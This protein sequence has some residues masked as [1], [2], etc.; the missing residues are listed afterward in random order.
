[1]TN[2][3]VTGVRS[4]ELGVTDLDRSA[5]FYSHIWGLE[6]VASEGDTVHLRANA[7]EHH[8]VTLR[9]RPKAG[10]LGVH[11]ATGDRAA[12]DGLHAKAKA[13]GATVTT[14]PAELPASAGGGYGFQFR[15]PEGHVLNIA[16]DVAQH[17]SVVNDRSKPVKLSH[18][19]L[20]SARIEEQTNFFID[21]LGFK[22][23]DSTQMMD[24]V[25]CCAD[26]H[27]IA[28][29]R[30][31][32]PSLNH[33]AYEVASIDGLMRGAGRLKHNGFNIEWGVGRHGPGDNV[34]SYF[35]EPNGFVVEY[36]T[37]IEQVDEATFTP[38][39][40]AY[41]ANFPGRPCRWGMAGLPS[42]R[43]RAAMGG[44]TSVA[45][46]EDGKRCEEIMAQKLGR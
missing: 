23:S 18:V 46:P 40:A 26:H 21:L 37:E 17:P 25:R 12:V 24:F 38:H 34:F 42:N 4:V 10:M 39:D 14:A 27:S 20:N 15:T 2:A 30:G 22:L 1:M 3:K 6:P 16:S 35:V 7:A 19:V 31:A 8:I 43:I 11:F 5:A 33:M 41:W 45:K 44:D 9:E 36:T 28:M 13:F 29:A 32:G